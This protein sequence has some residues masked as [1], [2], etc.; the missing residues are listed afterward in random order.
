MDKDVFNSV[1]SKQ[2]SIRF[3]SIIINDNY[4]EEERNIFT[5]KRSYEKMNPSSK[6]YK[7]VEEREDS[8][9]TAYI[10]NEER[11]V[12][13][14]LMR[15]MI[16]EYDGNFC[17]DLSIYSKDKK[18]GSISL[19]RIFA[20]DKLSIIDFM[21]NESPQSMDIAHYICDND[22]YKVKDSFVAI[23]DCFVLNEEYQGIGLEKEIICIL[24]SFLI[25]CDFEIS[26][27]YIKAISISYNDY[28]QDVKS[29]QMLQILKDNEYT[30]GC[31]KDSIMYSEFWDFDLFVDYREDID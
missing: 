9:S 10:I 11:D 20:D 14:S 3:D 30:L 29:E 7:F 21:D 22:F 1:I 5:L 17:F 8:L 31:G 16:D 28:G 26:K 18:I 15:E 12:D 24:D 23:Y 4:E 13:Y 25:E 19:T 2:L 27:T 6:L